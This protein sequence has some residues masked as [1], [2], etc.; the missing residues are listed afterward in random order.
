MREILRTQEKVI[1]IKRKKRIK[2]IIFKRK[3]LFQI[4]EILGLISLNKIRIFLTNN[5]KIRRVKV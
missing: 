3:G 5:N 2:K 1:K 4:K